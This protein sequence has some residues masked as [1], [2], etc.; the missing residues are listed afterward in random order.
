LGVNFSWLCSSKRWYS[1]QVSC[2]G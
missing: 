2:C 1:F